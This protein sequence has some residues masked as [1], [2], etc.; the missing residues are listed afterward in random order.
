MY[1][2]L[3]FQAPLSLCDQFQYVAD[4][5]MYHT[6]SSSNALLVAPHFNESIFKNSLLSMDQFPR[7]NYHYHQFALV[8]RSMHL[9]NHICHSK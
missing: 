6:R 5:Q 3:N 4:Y 7:T 2:C 8:N 9:K 1:K